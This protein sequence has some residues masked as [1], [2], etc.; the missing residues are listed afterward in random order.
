MRNFCFTL[1]G[2]IFLLNSMDVQAICDDDLNPVLAGIRVAPP[3]LS[4]SRETLIN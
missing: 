4:I 2:A 1:F 3:E